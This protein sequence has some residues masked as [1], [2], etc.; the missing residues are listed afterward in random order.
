[1]TL[2]VGVRRHLDQ[3]E[4][5]EQEWVELHERS[6]AALPFSAPEWAV[7]WLRH[8][9]GPGPDS[10][11]VVEVREAGELVG[12]APLYQ[13]RM[14]GGLVRLQPVGTGVEWVGPFEVPSMLA[15]A[16]RG[17]DVGRAVVEHLCRVEPGW[18]WANVA[19]GEAAP[20][21]EP[22]WLPDPSFTS[23]VRH[24]VG[25]VVLDLRV[26]RPEDVLAGHRNLKES[27]RRAR[28][29]LTKEFGPE[30]WRVHRHAL[31]DD[32]DAALGRLMRL[33]GER[34]AA[35]GHRETHLDVFESARVRAYVTDVVHR[36]ALR[37]RVRVYEVETGGEVLAAQLV[38][39]T[40]TAGYA[41]VSGVSEQGWRFSSVTHL[42]WQ[43]VVDSHAAGHAEL[44][45][46]IGPNQAKLRW[47]DQ[48]RHFPDY[49]VLGP[50]RRSRTAYLAAQTAAA[51]RSYREAVRAH[52]A[53]KA[54]LPQEK[55]AG[56][57]A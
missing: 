5:L 54:G 50:R 52:G 46:S 26:D 44:N 8:F 21:L 19:L 23:M 33:H 20:W 31:P 37:D 27:L 57:Q 36:L 32:V 45:L 28:N 12:V 38:L 43:A 29:R 30:G 3:V 15:A 24:V 49:V 56:P 51:V 39:R 6:G 7:T 4:G 1:V 13:H 55:G 34:A 10:P 17:R 11:L 18:D 2:E 40:A 47:S 9:T 41:S 53:P 14:R 48:V 16:G 35:D 42:L 25:A 22:E